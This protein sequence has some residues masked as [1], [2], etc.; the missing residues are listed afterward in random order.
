M[1]TSAALYRK[2]IGTR[3]TRKRFCPV[4]SGVSTAVHAILPHEASAAFTIGLTPL[5]ALS[6]RLVSR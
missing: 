3:Q 4:T 5:L 1:L 2:I 6:V